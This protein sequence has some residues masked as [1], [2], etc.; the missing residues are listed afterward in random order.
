MIEQFKTNIAEV[1]QRIAAAAA[2]SGRT[3]NDIT[4]VGVTK[5]V[6]AATT[7]AF[8]EAGCRVLGENRPQ[9]LWQKRQEL[10]DLDIEWHLIGHLQRNKA[11]RMVEAASLIHSVDSLRLLKAIDGYAAEQNRIVRVLLEVNVSGEEAKHGFAAEELPAVI[12]S[13]AGFSAVKV[14]GL[15]AMAGLLGDQEDARREFASMRELKDRLGGL[16][17]PANVQMS[18]LSMGMSGDYEIAI[19]EGATIVRVGSALFHGVN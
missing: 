11:K 13:V 18:E 9:Q 5:Y 3:E 1:K 14:D 10:A 19:E 2:E 12:E 17:L 8:A 15:M 6:D 7:R 4:L 16:E